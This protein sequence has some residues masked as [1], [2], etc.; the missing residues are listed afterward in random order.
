MSVHPETIALHAGFR[1]D[2]A[3]GAAAPP[4]YQTTSYQFADTA[5]ATRFFS[6]REVGYT[7]TRTANPTRE[8]AER[9]IAALEGGAAALLLASGAAARLYALVNLAESGDNFVISADVGDLATFAVTLERMGFGVRRADP[10]RPASFAEATDART[11]AYFAESLPEASLARFPIAEVAALGRRAG[12]PLIVDNRALPLLARPFA[13]GAAVVTNAADAY[14]GGHGIAGP[15]AIVDG[16]N[17]P[18]AA[19]RERFPRLAAP[20]PSYNGETWIEVAERFGVA[21]P[22]LMRARLGCLRDLGGA[23][24]PIEAFLALQGIETLPLRIAAHGR[25]AAAIAAFLAA[26][27]AVARLTYPGEGG[28][29]RFDLRRGDP[30]GFAARLELIRPTARFGE[31][32]SGIRVREDGGLRLSVGLEHPDDIAADLAAA[33]GG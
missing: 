20:D 6:L 23:V 7:Y 10:A 5:Q 27:P 25:G 2:P 13:L 30:L 28:L 18:W 16:G 11:R 31:A 9:R 12:V 17:F 4:I 8:F 26:H 32:R 14:L 22:Y 24:S 29:L 3:T 1:A 15:G 19:H 21:I 33:L